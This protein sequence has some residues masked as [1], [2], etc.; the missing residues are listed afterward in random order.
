MAAELPPHWHTPA[1]VRNRPIQ[2]KP[3]PLEKPGRKPTFTRCSRP[4]VTVN[5]MHY[6][7]VL[8]PY[9]FRYRRLG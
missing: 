7:T 6:S 2:Q 4:S 8:F 1:D 9:N 3:F 5:M